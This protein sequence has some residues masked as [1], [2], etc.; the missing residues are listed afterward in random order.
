V[1]VVLLAAGRG[2][3]LKQVTAS[4]PKILVPLHNGTSLLERQLD[5]LLTEGVDEVTINVCHFA[6]QV[7]ET[8]RRRRRGPRVVVSREEELTGTAGALVRLPVPL[9]ETTIVLYGDVVTDVRLSG[10]LD[11]HRRSG[12]MATLVYHVGHGK[13]KGVLDVAPDGRVLRFL[14]KPSSP[15]AEACVSAGICVV[16]PRLLEYVTEIPSDLG[17]DVWPR[18]LA[19]GEHLNA[20]RTRSY[21]CDVGTLAGLARARA[22]LARG[23][24]GW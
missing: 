9:R 2:T 10:L 20:V 4:I 8:L 1:R 18:A 23:V 22:D 17:A 6:D 14:E 21:V 7:L 13:E 3:R 12:A 11:S 19:A 24:F 15:P 5:Y 16:E